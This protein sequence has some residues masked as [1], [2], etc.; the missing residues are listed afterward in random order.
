MGDGVQSPPAPT[1][2][3][4]KPRMRLGKG[5]AASF[6]TM[7]KYKPE[8]GPVNIAKQMTGIATYQNASDQSL[9]PADAAV[10][11]GEEC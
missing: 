4:S 5:V 7:I 8:R 2:A 6:F 1:L 10:H 9:P 3:Y 11:L